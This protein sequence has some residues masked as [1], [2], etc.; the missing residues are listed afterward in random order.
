[1]KRRVVLFCLAVL[2][3][4]AASAQT[5]Q[6]FVKTKGRVVNGKHVAG[7]GLQGAVVA[8]HGRSS[9]GVQN[10]NGS[11]SFP[12]VGKSYTVQSVTKN[13]YQLVD[14]DA[15][16]KA[17]AYSSNPL[18]LVMETPGQQQADRVD[19]ERKLRR[20]LQQ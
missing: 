16:P 4:V 17:Y 8:L 11:F 20:T 12:V 14:A 2:T 15:A 19:A 9:V 6:G 7:K 13:G 5:Q 1:M 18:Y 10:A 3:A